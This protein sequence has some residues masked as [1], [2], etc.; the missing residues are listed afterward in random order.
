MQANP[1]QQKAI[2]HILGPFICIAG[3]GSGKT[4][5][6]IHRVLNLI[7]NGVSP[8]S[9]LVV[10]FTKAAAK[11][12]DE[13]YKKLPGSLP[14]PVFSTIHSFAFNVIKA[15]YGYKADSI[16][17]ENE[18]KKYLKK[19]IRD[20]DIRVKGSDANKLCKNIISDISSY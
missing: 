15:R 2:D 3:P 16:I 18:Q 14:G 7:K 5:V 17:D 11:E 12:M 4:T 1:D 8:D 9:I 10:T 6:I 20:N 13:R 19:L